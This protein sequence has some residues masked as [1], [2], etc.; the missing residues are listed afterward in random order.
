MYT[1]RS[2]IRSHLLLLS[3][4]CLLA[5]GVGCDEER[6]AETDLFEQAEQLL[7]IGDSEAANRNYEEFLERY[8]QSPLAPLARERLANIDRQLESIMGRRAAPAPIYIRPV[9][10]EREPGSQESPE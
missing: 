8:P 2:R 4:G 7:R 10:P 1:T 6:P 3:L 9:A 5:C